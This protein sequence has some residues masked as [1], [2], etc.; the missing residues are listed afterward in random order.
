MDKRD[1]S[2]REWQD[3]KEKK[4]KRKTEKR[5]DRKREPEKEATSFLSALNF[6]SKKVDKGPPTYSTCLNYLLH[7]ILGCTRPFQSGQATPLD[8]IPCRDSCVG[9][10]S[11]L[12]ALGVAVQYLFLFVFVSLAV[13]RLCKSPPRQTYRQ[14]PFQQFLPGCFSSF[15]NMYEL[16]VPAVSL[17]VTPRLTPSQ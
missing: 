13:R 12:L 3:G 15:F 1:S 17:L 7:P 2:S 5:R 16:D 14:R 10:A 4:R 11:C 6:H 8:F 9:W